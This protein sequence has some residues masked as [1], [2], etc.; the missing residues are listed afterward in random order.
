MSSKGKKFKLEGRD[1]H[2]QVLCKWYNR[3]LCNRG[4]E[5]TFAHA[6]NYPGCHKKHPRCEHHEVRPEIGQPPAKKEKGKGKGK[7][8]SRSIDMA[9]IMA[10][11][12]WVRIRRQE[13]KEEEAESP[14]DGDYGAGE[15]QEE[16]QSQ[17]VKE[18][19][20][21]IPEDGD[22]GGDESQEEEQPQPDETTAHEAAVP[23]EGKEEEN[24]GEEE[25]ETPEDGDYGG[26]ESQ[27]EEQAQ[28]DEMTTH[29]SV[30]E[31]EERPGVTDELVRTRKMWKRAKS[32]YTLSKRGY[33]LA[34]QPWATGEQAQPGIVSGQP[35]TS[36]HRRQAGR[37]K[38][39]RPQC[40]FGPG[41][42]VDRKSRTVY[43]SGTRAMAA[44]VIAAKA[45]KL[46]GRAKGSI[47]RRSNRLLETGGR[48]HGR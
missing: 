26:D 41:P 18:E 1:Q 13:V 45:K 14:E 30:V 35:R 40:K 28:P 32:I 47:A 38:A 48:R 44:A 11:H 37:K 20:E 39:M 2:G 21:E 29:E 25:E 22:Y 34:P 31:E 33:I 9:E 46:I 15:S 23:Q 19:E 4:S 10:K 8:S 5:C 43:V 16:E 24:E 36:S 6:C 3:G 27:E 12:G 42:V 17:E 7:R